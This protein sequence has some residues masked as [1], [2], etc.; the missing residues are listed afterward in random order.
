MDEPDP[1]VVAAAR[2]GDLGAFERL[3]RRYQGDVWRMSLY[4]LHDQDLASD[5]TQD[6]FVRAFRF[7]DRYRGESR[8]T[9]WLLAI[10]RNCA[11]DELRRKQRRERVKERVVAQP[12][13]PGADLSSALEVREAVA[14]LEL[15]LRE[16]VVLIDMFGMSY[17]EVSRMCGVPIGTIKSRM[18]RARALLAE[19]LDVDVGGALDEG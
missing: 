1:E 19:A 18:H 3:V 9:V 2:G 14:S 5:V 11:T 16:P 12:K 4:L 13:N 6:T 7:L 10:A 15:E 17:A 8:F